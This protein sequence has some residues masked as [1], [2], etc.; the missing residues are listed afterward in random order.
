MASKST[1]DPPVVVYCA[2]VWWAGKEG[3]SGQGVEDLGFEEE[4][5]LIIR[6]MV[7]E[8]E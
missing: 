2:W 1:R 7:A 4:G 5:K 8:C 6:Q 3:K